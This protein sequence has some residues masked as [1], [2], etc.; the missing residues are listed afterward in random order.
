MDA[1][2]F[3]RLAKRLANRRVSRRAALRGA[4][5]LALAGAA[6]LQAPSLVG[7]AAPPPN[8]LVI[9]VDEMRE[10]QWFPD[11]A[12]VDKQLPALAGL[13]NGAVQFTHNYTASNACTPS[14]A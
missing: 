6:G 12:T 13:R 10:S 2:H 5:G 14:R 11:Q 8:I 7:A 4:G 1:E 9:I 3:D